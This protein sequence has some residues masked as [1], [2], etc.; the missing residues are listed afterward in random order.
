MKNM[1]YIFTA[2]VAFLSIMTSRAQVSTYY[3]NFSSNDGKFCIG[4]TTH[5]NE[6]DSVR[7]RTV[8]IT[9]MPNRHFH[10]TVQTAVFA[11]GETAKYI[12]IPFR[13]PEQGSDVE[14]YSYAYSLL[15]SRSY[16]FEVLDMKERKILASCTR[17]FETLTTKFNCQYISNGED[18]AY[19]TDDGTLSSG[20]ASD[21]YYDTY[22]EESQNNWITVLDSDA[23]NSLYSISLSDFY[24]VALKG[25]NAQIARLLDYI[26][27]KMY[28]TVGFT[29][30][31]ENDGYQYIQICNGDLFDGDDSEG[32]V[33]TP[34]NSLYK[35][36]FILSYTPSGSVMTSPHKQ[37]FPHRYNAP[38]K[39]TE[40]AAQLTRFSFDYDNSHM[41]KQAFKSDD[42]IASNAGA[43]S[44]SPNFGANRIRVRFDAAGSGSDTW[45]FKDLFVR[46]TFVDN[47]KPTLLTSPHVVTGRYYRKS[48]TTIYIPF[49][50][51]VRVTGT[52]TITTSWGT[53]T[54]DGGDGT[55]VLAFSGVIDAPIGTVLIVSALNGTV[56]DVV[57]NTFTW[58]GVHTSMYSET[59]RRSN[60]FEDM[61]T[62]SQGRVIIKTKDD[63]Y[64]LSMYQKEGAVPDGTSFIQTAN[65]VCDENFVPIGDNAHPFKGSYDGCGHVIS[66]ITVNSPSDSYIGVFGKVSGTSK[67]HCAIEN[68]VVSGSTFTGAHYVGGIVGYLGAFS[69]VKNCLVTNITVNAGV[70]SASNI[71]GIVGECMA[72]ATNSYSTVEGCLSAAVINYEGISNPTNL[73][74]IV[75]Y[76]YSNVSNSQAIVKNCLYVGSSLDGGT[77]N[78]RRGPTVG[79][80]YGR[81]VN[82]YHTN[83]AVSGN[84]LARTITLSGSVDFE[85][86]VVSY[87]L[88][89]IQACGESAIRYNNKYISCYNSTVTLKYTGSVSS[90]M[91]V[92]YK[93]NGEDI[94][95]RS[96]TMPANDVTIT[97]S[98]G[99]SNELLLYATQ[100]TVMGK[101]KYVATFYHSYRCYS[102]PDGV[103]A[104]IAT[105]M[106]DD[107]VL[108]ELKYSSNVIPPGTA[109]ILIGDSET[110]QISRNDSV[111]VTAPSGNVLR[112]SNTS[113]ALSNGKIGNNVPYVLSI[114]DGTLNFYKFTGTA[115]PAGKIYIF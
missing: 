26:G 15:S 66:G 22:Y 54:Y 18:L 96:F 114:S 75:G 97:A 81:V 109:V 82:T 19:F 25:H 90:D 12:S 92:T 48:R 2:L 36:C 87:P 56:T 11:A 111:S 1:K 40:K 50:E 105:Q 112:G 115:I 33:S 13:F 34:S 78:N 46:T 23:Y 79:H 45:Y 74:G 89:N 80:S 77:T 93:V 99:Y 95:G 91:L 29:Q 70:N 58:S 67:N 9:T 55:N 30:K 14:S 42:Y 83:S 17:S 108:K 61:D 103:K 85:G 104:Y 64:K 20:V 8:G 106:G 59:V 72:D 65:I 94:V 47:V 49:K 37:F 44:L 27:D 76:L 73:G 68:L 88:T 32:S 7:Y 62:D 38:D 84:S 35:A 107:I 5:I 31:E 98:A 28:V 21:K 53:F 43:I 69:I 71:G 110:I 6:V 100:A 10:E 101:T 24:E 60:T 3:V 63:L 52:P 102:L 39:A 113:T 4:R 16:R 86:D 57:G 51:I 41:Y